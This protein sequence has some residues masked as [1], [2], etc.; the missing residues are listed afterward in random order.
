MH[1]LITGAAGFIGSHFVKR[2]LDEGYRVSVFDKLTY[3][4]NGLDRLRDV[5][6]RVN[7]FTADFS[8]PISEGLVQELGDVTHI[9]HMGGE[10]HVDR[11]IENPELF[12]KSNVCGTVNMLQLA[13]KIVPKRFY[14]FSTDEVFGPAPEGV[15]YGEYDTHLP[16]NPYAASKSAAEQMVQAFAHTYVVPCVITRTMNVFGEWQHPEKFIPKVIGKVLTGET[17]SIHADPTRTIAGSRFY[18]HASDVADAY[19]HIL[20]NDLPGPYHIVGARE[21][22]NLSLAQMIADILRKE[23]KHEM[24]DF[25]SSRPGHDLR[26]ALDGSKL[27]EAG[28]SAP[29][30][31]TDKLKQTINWY[32][33]NPEWIRSS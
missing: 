15:R 20:I 5:R 17:V 3:A 21:L 6:D 24:V 23:L 2:F 4:A 19:A 18:V 10:T 32:L 1:V 13:R 28:W 16:A 30:D 9:I 31:I 11:S 33:E 8:E 12:V 29:D 22:D 25:H 27:K 26:Y 14:F 7:V